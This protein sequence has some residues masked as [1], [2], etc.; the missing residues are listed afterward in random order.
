[1]HKVHCKSTWHVQSCVLYGVTQCAQRK[2]GAFTKFMLLNAVRS[3]HRHVPLCDLL[4]P[5]QNASVTPA[6]YKFAANLREL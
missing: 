1:M 6:T 2:H 4:V 3:F 5:L